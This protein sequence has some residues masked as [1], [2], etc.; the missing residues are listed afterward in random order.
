MRNIDY[1]TTVELETD[2]EYG[3]EDEILIQPILK[4][5]VDLMDDSFSY[6]GTHCTHGIGGTHRIPKYWDVTDNDILWNKEDFTEEQNKE[7]EKYIDSHFEYIRDRAVVKHEEN[8][9]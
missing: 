1:K 7:I 3:K 5:E 6:A 4:V 8:N 2:V 9:S